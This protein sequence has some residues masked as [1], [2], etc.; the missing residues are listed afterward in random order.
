MTL[1]AFTPDSLDDL[2]LRILDLAGVVRD[3]ANTSRENGLD[4]M[5]LH[6]NKVREWLTRLEDWANDGSAKLE[7][8]VIK[9]R[10][11]RRAQ[12]ARPGA[13]DKKRG[14]RRRRKFASRK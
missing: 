4:H 3:M 11:A 14:A 2:A 8:S 10:G 12:S 5:S 13:G 9:L 6:V 7:T 1:A